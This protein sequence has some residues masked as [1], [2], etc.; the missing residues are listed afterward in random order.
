M[1][2]TN[3]EQLNGLESGRQREDRCTWL[4]VGYFYPG[5][6][7]I[8]AGTGIKI[9]TD[10]TQAVYLGRLCEP[11]TLTEAAYMDS[12]GWEWD[13]NTKPRARVWV[14]NVLAADLLKQSRSYEYDGELVVVSHR[15]PP[16]VVEESLWASGF[17][18]SL[19]TWRARSS[20][21]RRNLLANIIEALNGGTVHAA[22]APA[23]KKPSG[24]ISE[25]AQHAWMRWYA[26]FRTDLEVGGRTYK[27]D[28]RPLLRDDDLVLK[29]R[30]PSSGSELE[31]EFGVASHPFLHDVTIEVDGQTLQRDS[32]AW[33]NLPGLVDEVGKLITAQKRARR[34]S[35]RTTQRRG[36]SPS[37]SP[38]PS[39][40]TTERPPA[41]TW[42]Q[43]VQDAFEQTPGYRL[44]IVARGLQG[45]VIAVYP[46]GGGVEDAVVSVDVEGDLIEGVRWLSGRLTRGVQDDLMGRLEEALAT[47][48][49]VMTGKPA[50][51]IDG[52]IAM[53]ERR[54]LVLGADP[55][56]TRSRDPHDFLARALVE[57]A[58]PSPSTP[59]EVMQWLERAGFD[60]AADL[61]SK[62]RSGDGPSD[63]SLLTRQLWTTAIGPLPTGHAQKEGANWRVPCESLYS[64][65]DG[66]PRVLARRLLPSGEY[67]LYIIRVRAV[68]SPT[69]GG[70][71]ICE[72]ADETETLEPNESVYILEHE[73]AVYIELHD[74]IR[75]FLEEV[76]RTSHRLED[77][78]RLLYWTAAMID[79]P[80]CQGQHRALVR[81]AF[82]EAMMFYDAARLQLAHGNPVVA[83]QRV[84]D[85]LRRLSSAAAAMAQACAEGQMPLTKPALAP[86]PEDVAVLGALARADQELSLQ[87]HPPPMVPSLTEP[88]P[89]GMSAP[90]E[91][92]PRRAA[93]ANTTV[94]VRTTPPGLTVEQDQ[95]Q[96]PDGLERVRSVLARAGISA[97]HVG[98][99]TVGRFGECRTES[100]GARDLARR[101]LCDAGITAS[102]V[103]GRLVFP[104]GVP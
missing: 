24:K 17:R 1:I 93:A 50:S 98:V 40:P 12:G 79:T 14:Q 71:T 87:K 26:V 68:R 61:I 18:P 84:H 39:A 45:H 74:R 60:K 6:V 78:R 76:E 99:R 3:A 59:A 66:Q 73:P 33:E 97:D 10:G 70:I 88:E 69:E 34:S 21:A 55:A 15:L 80:R 83:F 16:R 94:M 67:F 52:L 27:M 89:T 48:K 9:R 5:R 102:I 37:P 104:L 28:G 44:D 54:G 46:E 4:E 100:P 31:A 19:A 42:A 11:D 43:A 81:R 29:L 57:L 20:D 47:A 58:E 92:G 2:H 75:A 91:S 30:H 53:M 72:I 95:Q 13:K 7:D 32:V 49:K 82:V 23:V 96:Q 62:Y 90:R 86:G 103:R 63:L 77:V 85:A 101:V 51:P 36:P 65:E 64:G 25:L 22:T 41:V 38:S 8:Q 35:G 56:R